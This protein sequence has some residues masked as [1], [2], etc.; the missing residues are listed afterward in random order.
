MTY[1]SRMDVLSDILRTLHLR[2]EVFLHACFRG[3]WAVDTSGERRATFHM[4]ASGGCWL[5]MDDL[6]EPIALTGGDIIVFPHDAAH[7]LSN[8]ESTPAD[9]FPRNQVPALETQ[10]PA[11]ILICGYFDFDRHS[12]NP[13][14]ESLP[15]VLVIRNEDALKIPLMETL[16]RFLTYEVE[17][18]QAGSNLLIDKLS[19]ILFIHVIR[20]YME[21]NK[22]KGFIAAL[23][24]KHIGNALSKIHEKP[25][26][27]WSVESLAQAVGMSRSAF[28]ERFSRL[29]EMTPMSYLT[30]WRMTQAYEIF[31]TS[32]QS[33]AQVAEQC[34]YQSEV[35]FAKAF[36]KHFGFGPGQARKEKTN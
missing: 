8:S 4:V 24:D 15:Q 26:E 1:T 27:N 34:G 23:A 3:D 9:D 33:V 11:V 35:A 31:L 22:E 12:W 16:G 13:L 6:P 32:E 14:L 21:K 20:S 18:T 2:A 17:S 30:H 10:G 5:H 25:S 29:V 7:T 36:K 19:E 28:A